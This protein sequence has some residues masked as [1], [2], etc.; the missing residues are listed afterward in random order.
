MMNQRVGYEILSLLCVLL[1]VAYGF[2]SLRLINHGVVSPLT[3][4]GRES[5]IRSTALFAKK[6]KKNKQGNAPSRSQQQSRSDQFDAMTRKFMFTCSK[7]NKV[8]PD[9][10]RTILKDINLCFFPGAKIGVVGSNGSGKSSL[11]K[12]MAGVDKDFEG[13]ESVVVRRCILMICFN[14]ACRGFITSYRRYSM[15][16]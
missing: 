4:T 9:S 5:S 11:L 1:Q 6:G 7:V 13:T 12:I 3:R 8:L 16:H 2:R 14:S 15:S 10:S